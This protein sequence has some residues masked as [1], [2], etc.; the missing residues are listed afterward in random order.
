MRIPIVALTFPPQ[1]ATSV[2][3]CVVVHHYP[4]RWTIDLHWKMEA[5][6]GEIVPNM[7]VA[8]LETPKPK[9][10]ERS[11][12]LLKAIFLSSASLANVRHEMEEAQGQMLRW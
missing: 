11:R 9:S 1:N 6:T 4:E 5:R 7:Y 3:N 10:V 2:I 8:W 12:V